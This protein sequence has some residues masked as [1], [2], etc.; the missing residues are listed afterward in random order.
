MRIA[1]HFYHNPNKQSRE[2]G[3]NPACVYG[4]GIMIMRA[5]ASVTWLLLAAGIWPTDYALWVFGSDILLQQGFFIW[6]F[7][8]AICGWA[9][10]GCQIECMAADG[11][12]TVL[13]FHLEHYTERFG[14]GSTLTLSLSLT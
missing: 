2:T 12:L 10:R 7:M 13:P 8:V 14:L 1:Y 11:H 5:T 3:K 9:P 6:K 4:V